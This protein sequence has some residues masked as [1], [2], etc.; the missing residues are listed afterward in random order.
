MQS[1]GDLVR[2]PHGERSFSISFGCDPARVD[3]L[4]AATMSEIAS[5]QKDGVAPEYL[6]KVKQAWL[7]LREKQLRENPFWA[8]WLLT[9]YRYGDDP[10]IVL[11]PNKMVERAT[12][13]NV[14]AA[15]RR[16]LDA[17]QYFL[18]VLLPEK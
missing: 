15:A 10:A 17:K 5:I 8:R 9:S 6:E 13:E 4:V 18:A 3:E 12:S 16:Y 11:D 2:S 1:S 14:K 7:R